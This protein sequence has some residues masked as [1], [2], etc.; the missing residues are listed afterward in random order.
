MLDLGDQPWGN[1]FRVTEDAPKYPLKLVFCQN[2]GTP[3]LSVNV[4]KN[5][6]FADHTYLSGS[7]KTLSAYF[8]ECAHYVY[9]NLT[10]SGSVLDIGSN[11]GTQLK[12]FQQLGFEVLG[13]EPSATACALA[14]ER[15]IPTSQE[16]FNLHFA[17]KSEQQFDVINASGVFFHL[18]ELHSACQAIKLLLKDDGIFLVHCLY[19]KSICENTAFDQIY[20]EHLLYYN[21]SN[22]RFL[23]N[24]FGLEVQSCSLHS[25]HGG[26]LR[27]VVTH[28]ETA[29]VDKSIHDFLD[30]E[31]V[32]GVN[33]IGYYEDFASRVQ[34][35]REKNVNYVKRCL[36]DKKVIYGL[37]APVKGNTLLNFF[38]FG[39][40]EIKCLTE[41]NELRR[42][43]VAPGSNIPVVIDD[44]I[45]Q[46]PDIYYVLA[47]NFKEEILSRY[48]DLIES[49]VEFYFPIEIKA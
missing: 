34:A 6:M 33:K 46:Q 19:M 47:W 31:R 1:D 2:C 39:I 43:M 49:G 28:V 10:T 48:A 32:S 24:R 18:E 27:V 29:K 45:D 36:H 25:I 16:F 12:Y 23:L 9:D 20:H 7:T 8:R 15:G 38:G 30:A 41:I 42:G 44:E 5:V 35:L 13:V 4:P 14:R 21:L 22:L 40:D 37:G 17:K 26:T 3:Q 11:D